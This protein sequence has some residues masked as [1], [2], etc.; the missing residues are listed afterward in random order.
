MPWALKNRPLTSE[1]ARLSSLSKHLPRERGQ[2]P[3][4]TGRHK[5]PNKQVEL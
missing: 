4:G 2:T 1:V 3:R 5:G